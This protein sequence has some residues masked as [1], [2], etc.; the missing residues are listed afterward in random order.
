MQLHIHNSLHRTREPFVPADEK[1]VTLY[2]CGPTVYNYAHIGNARPAVV[3]DVLFRLLRRL[4]GEQH[5]IYARNF[6][7]VDDKINTA[8]AEQNVEIKVI[9]DR[10]E[11]AYLEDMH[12]LGVLDPDLQPHA[13]DH[14]P[15]IITMIETLI[16]RGHAYAAEGHVL[17]DV[18]S[19]EHYGELA[20]RDTE[21]ML[22][23]ARVEVAPYKRN[24]G[25]FVLW[26]PSTGKQPGWDS[27][28]GYGRPGWHIECSAM[29]ATHLGEV[30]DIHGGGQDLL[31][32]HHE[33]ELAQSRCAHGTEH[34]ARYWMHNGF[35]TFDK[36]KMS[37]SLGNVLL[38]KNLREQHPPEAL[39]LLLLSA[40]Y[41]QPLDWS[42]QALVDAR[43]TLDRY[44][45]ALRKLDHL[46]A[47]PTTPAAFD[48]A[49]CDDL[50]TPQ[51]LAVLADT[52]RSANAADNDQDR[53]RLKGEIL[54]CAQALGLLWQDPNDW[55]ATGSEDVDN[56]AIDAKVAE[57][58]EARRNKD[59][60][61]ADELRDELAA[62]NV[63]IEDDP[64]G[65]RWRI[66]S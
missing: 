54:G 48:Q 18:T 59:W 12:A 3:F 23:G 36:R 34:F 50:N 46:E 25:D 30:I 31:F 41:R 21:E 51:A 33:N 56:A 20:H 63:V 4:Y 8:A 58:D 7:D 47:E 43:R 60:A 37:K 10:F 55:F 42:E 19:F 16:E 32:P 61:R 22:A 28:W 14:I 52:V 15:Q 11:A 39:R 38:I 53:I 62:M 27:P 5:V 66:G 45:E 65:S 9:T 6:T 29:S 26:K 35:L 2:V 49:L 1:R 24:P 13:T 64:S 17:F 44:Y 40:H 57:R